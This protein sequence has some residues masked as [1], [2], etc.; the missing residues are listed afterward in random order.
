MLPPPENI[1]VTDC[2]HTSNQPYVFI[3]ISNILQVWLFLK[4]QPVVYD[5][6]TVYY[7]SE[8]CVLKSLGVVNA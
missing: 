6:R 3:M 5:V 8:E 7:V 2:E 1:F 4:W